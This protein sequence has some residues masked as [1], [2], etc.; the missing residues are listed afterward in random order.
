MICILQIK[1]LKAQGPYLQGDL[2]VCAATTITYHI[3]NYNANNT[4]T[5]TPS[6]NGTFGSL[7][8]GTGAGNGDFTITWNNSAISSGGSITIA[9]NLA[10]PITTTIYPCCN[11][12]TNNTFWGT[13]IT[14]PGHAASASAMYSIGFASF[15]AFFTVTN[16]SFS[17]NGVFTVDHNLEFNNCEV[18]LGAGASIVVNPSV[19]LK[20]TGSHLSSCGGNVLWKGISA[21]SLTGG[22][23]KVEIN[24][25]LIEDAKKA[26]DMRYGTSY[27][28]TNS[29]FNKN[30][31]AIYMLMYTAAYTTPTVTNVTGNV[32]SCNNL[33]SYIGSTPSGIAAA[34]ISDFQNNVS[35]VPT[36]TVTIANS[37]SRYGIYLDHV[38]NTNL[39]LFPKIGDGNGGTPSQDINYYNNLGYGIYGTIARAFVYNSQFLHIVTDGIYFDAQGQTLQV[40]DM[41]AN[42]PNYFFDCNEDINIARVN[43]TIMNNTFE[44]TRTHCIRNSGQSSPPVS[45]TISGQNHFNNFGAA[46]GAGYGVFLQSTGRYQTTIIDNF[47]VQNLSLTGQSRAICLNVTDN[48]FVP[49]TTNFTPGFVINNNYIEFNHLN[50]NVNS[51]GVWINGGSTVGGVLPAYVNANVSSNTIL[52]ATTGIYVINKD[53]I[54]IGG[55][56]GPSM[57]PYGTYGNFINFFRPPTVFNN[58]IN[59]GYGIR[60]VYSYNPIVT[61][62]QIGNYTVP[63]PLSLGTNKYEF[64]NP[65]S[66]ALFLRGISAENSGGYNGIKI[67]HNYISSMGNSVFIGGANSYSDILCNFMI[68]FLRGV[69]FAT[70]TTTIGDQAPSPYGAAN[71]NMFLPQLNGGICLTGSINTIARWN[72]NPAYAAPT[73]D[74]T[75]LT[76]LNVMPQT[77]SDQCNSNWLIPMATDSP[78]EKREKA[79][80][81]IIRD[82]INYILLPGEMKLRDSV[83]AYLFIDAD[84]SLLSLGTS[85]DA[86]YRAFYNA[87]KNSNIGKFKSINDLITDSVNTDTTAAIIINQNIPTNCTP[88]DNQKLVNEIYLAHIKADSVDIDLSD[89]YTIY[90]ST[91]IAELT[92]VA[93]QNPASGGMSVYMARGMLNIALND[94]ELE[95]GES[96]SLDFPLVLP[97][98]VLELKEN[99][100][101]PN[102]NNGKMYLNYTLADSQTGYLKLFN[103]AGALI[104]EYPLDKSKKQLLIN[105]SNLETG[106]YTYSIYMNET[107]VKT[108]KLI[109]N[110]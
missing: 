22:G 8:T 65:Y 42:D 12:G 39:P 31:T 70:G 75:T 64:L 44:H 43:A 16:Q 97:P 25:S 9:D 83:Y 101:Y 62:N 95:E 98:S 1:T 15:G 47:F 88:D 61:Y 63:S 77:A 51:C 80:G 11:S 90:D 57:G 105:E 106:V 55:T 89:P 91:E 67:R 93:Y 54:T 99:S 108:D 34:V 27:D 20:L 76:N 82:E 5:I 35:F 37:L 18:K 53:K 17:I 19:T 79:I 36:N 2:F 30:D 73:K 32:F 56:T 107:L 110:K 26:V 38:I 24:K 49:A 81:K 94:D 10:A 41:G 69:N 45:I 52:G 28:I 92:G 3:G 85:Q 103:Q 60:I 21:S 4:Y 23:R 59:I 46:G 68:G 74:I 66:L 33:S 109:I 100:L 7:I 84:T 13:A 96:K 72:Y 48:A 29:V 104:R 86:D 87:C 50:Y 71:G 14:N 40:G 58:S 102:P 6:A 78:D